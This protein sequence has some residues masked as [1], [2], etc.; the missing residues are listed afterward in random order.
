MQKE[1]F[2]HRHRLWDRLGISASA[3]CLVHCVA[4]PFLL[5]G[6]PTLARFESSL[7]TGFHIAMAVLV[8]AT[9]VPALR[10]GFKRHRDV[11]TLAFGGWGLSLILI[12]LLTSDGHG[13]HD[14]GSH[15]EIEHHAGH[16]HGHDHVHAA[17]DH[18][19]HDH[20]HAEHDHAAHDHDHA[21]HDHAAQDHGHAGHDDG[22]DHAEHQHSLMS[23]ESILTMLG[24]VFLVTAHVRNL[25][26][27][28]EGCQLEGCDQHD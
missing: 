15:A 28:R 13:G 7:G 16:D 25:S 2:R 3:L 24:S 6:I 12:G 5:A 20:D 19:A 22:G 11:P 17:H 23:R 21:E 27:C 10:G 1:Q 9:V 4:L 8:T 14:H 18:A 26:K